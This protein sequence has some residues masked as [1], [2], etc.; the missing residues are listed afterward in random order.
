MRLNYLMPFFLIVCS[1]Q[2]FSWG[3]KK[4]KTGDVISSNDV[5]TQDDY[6]I[7]YWKDGGSGTMT[8]ADGCDFSCQ[9]GSVN[10]ILFRKGVRPGSEKVIIVYTADY[11]PQGNSYL[12]IYGWFKN[13]L[14]EYYIIES[15]GSWKPPGN[16]TRKGTVET[17]S[18]KYEI[19]QNSRTG[20]SI[21]GNKTFQQYWSVRTAKRTKGTI[22]C[23]NHFDAWKKAGMTIGSFYEVSFN[24]EAYQSPG[25]QATV[26]VK[27]YKSLEEMISTSTFF[28]RQ[29]AP[30][31][32]LKNNAPIM[33]YNSL[34]QQVDGFSASVRRGQQPIIL[35]PNNGASGVF[36]S[37][38]S[39]K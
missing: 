37:H 27:M 29:A 24:V 22:T 11:K 21:E 3:S 2:I 35:N 20:A 33:L 16:A 6:H 38:Q 10:N 18:G 36:Y 31:L 13:P 23:G 8:L 14:V 28:S 17:D 5:G 39:K 19:F 9:W 1:S 25:G 12:S 34:G 7:E 15:W 4:F 26:Q 32:P 30:V